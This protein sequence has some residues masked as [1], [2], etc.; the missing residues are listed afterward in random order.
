M[1]QSPFDP[2]AFRAWIDAGQERHKEGRE[3]AS[4]QR[5][6]ERR[7]FEFLTAVSL[8]TPIQTKEHALKTLQDID[9]WEEKQLRPR[10]R[11]ERRKEQKHE[12]KEKLKA[13]KKEMADRSMRKDGKQQERRR[14]AEEKLAGRDENLRLTEH[15]AEL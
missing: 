4:E 12:D 2:Q 9:A 6:R 10:T 1:N 14:I 11:A 13:L 8:K 5:Q 7:A 3:G 15:D